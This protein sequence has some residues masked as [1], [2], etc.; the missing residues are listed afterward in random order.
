MQQQKRRNRRQVKTRV[1]S[2]VSRITPGCLGEKWKKTEKMK[3][4]TEIFP[5][6]FWSIDALE[7]KMFEL[8]ATTETDFSQRQNK[9]F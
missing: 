1:A 4:Q 5:E 2:V 7:T 3:N 8:P 6:S 9:C